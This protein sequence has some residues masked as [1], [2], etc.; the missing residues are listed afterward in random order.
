MIAPGRLVRLMVLDEARRVDRA[1]WRRYL[2]YVD[3]AVFAVFALALILLVRHTFLA[4]QLY[5]AGDWAALDAMWLLAG[6]GAF[7]VGALGWIVYRFF[8]NQYLVM[9]RPY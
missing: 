7:L 3:L 8:R 6:D 5:D 1:T 9:L 4:G 2:F